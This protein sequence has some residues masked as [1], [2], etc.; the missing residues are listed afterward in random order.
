MLLSDFSFLRLN[1]V[2]G[3]EQQKEPVEGRK[4]AKS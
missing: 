1:S 3:N 4:N 2:E